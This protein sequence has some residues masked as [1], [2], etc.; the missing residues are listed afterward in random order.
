MNLNRGPL[1]TEIRESTKDKN[2]T[3]SL[4]G[5][6]T[7]RR[8]NSDF[9]VEGESSWD[10]TRKRKIDELIHVTCYFASLHLHKILWNYQII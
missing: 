1:N 7:E 2:S 10:R 3:R 6:K 4:I 9:W 8:E 5:T